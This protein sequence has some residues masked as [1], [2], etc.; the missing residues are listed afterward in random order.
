MAEIYVVYD[1]K[2]KED[3]VMKKLLERHCHNRKIIKMFYQEARLLSR[4]NH[5][6]IQKVF[7]VG[8]DNNR[9]FVLMEY[10]KSSILRNLI[11]NNPFFALTKGL[12]ILYQVGLALDY[13][14][15]C[16]IIH[17][18]IK[19]ANVL[20]SDDL[21][22]KLTDFGMATTFFQGRFRFQRRVGG[23]PSYMSPEQINGRRVDRRSDIYS[24]GVM[25]YEILTG[26]LPF[27]GDNLNELLAKHMSRVSARPPSELIA[28]IPKAFDAVIVK[29]L[30]KDKDNRYSDMSHLLIDLSRFK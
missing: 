26:R 2:R 14:H 21:K 29:C 23:T 19:P 8:K 13:I 30:E 22:A 24:F 9:P 20:V 12:D 11:K 27:A 15:K 6:N 16:K 5:P 10:F 28:D 25:A 3:V 7:E 4:L 18:D 17:L 1:K